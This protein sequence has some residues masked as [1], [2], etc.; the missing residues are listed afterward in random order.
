MDLEVVERKLML[1]ELENKNLKFK[2]KTIKRNNQ[3]L[4]ICLIATVLFLLYQQLL[5]A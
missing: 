1:A 5:N 3:F 4:S 2:L